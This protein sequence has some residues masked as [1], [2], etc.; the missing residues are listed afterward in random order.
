VLVLVTDGQSFRDTATLAQAIAAARQ[1]RL[2]VYPVAVVTP[3]LDT[4]A[5]AE[6]AAAT[7]GELLR[8]QSLSDLVRVYRALALKVLSTYAVTYHS[9]AQPG[10]RID[11]VVSTGGSSARVALRA[12][13][14]LAIIR[15]SAP[16]LRVPTRRTE[17]VLLAGALIVGLLLGAVAI[18]KLTLRL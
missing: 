12:P 18:A 17:L 16:L 11:L 1:A 2:T 5:L 7:G 8:G 10:E 6:L 4:H 14:R 3:L 9:L 15:P 13:G